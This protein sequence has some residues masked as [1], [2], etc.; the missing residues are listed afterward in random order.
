MSVVLRILALMLAASIV[1]LTVVLAG[2]LGPAPRRRPYFKNAAD[3]RNH[4]VAGGKLD[5]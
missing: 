4:H 2:L 5:F 3:F 1:M